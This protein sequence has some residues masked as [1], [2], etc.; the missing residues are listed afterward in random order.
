MG[1]IRNFFTSLQRRHTLR[2]HIWQSLANYTQQGFGFLLGIVLARLLPPAVFGAYG[3]AAATVILAL[4]P[5]TWSLA[6]TLLADAGKTPSLHT[7]V[8]QFSW[9]IVAARCVIVAAVVIWCFRAG[10]VTLGWL[11][12]LVG[13]TETFRELNN[14]QKGY[15]EGLGKFAPNFV[16]VVINM[17]FC[18]VVVIPLA[19]FHGGP[20]VLVLPALG[21]VLTDFVIYRYFSARTILVRPRWNVSR[22]F[23]HHGFWLWLGA[24]SE[25]GLARFDK[26]FVGRFR[27]E[28]PLGHYSRAF[29]YTPL[30]WLGLSSFATN[31]TVAGLTRCGTAAARL[32]LF[33][34]TSAILFAGGLLNWLAFFFFADQIVLGLFGRQWAPTIPI[35]RAFASLSLAYMIAY[36]PMTVMLAHRRYR[37]LGIVRL[38]ALVAFVAIVLLCREHLSPTSVAWLLQGTLAMQGLIL[39]Y[40]G[41]SSFQEHTD[42]I[43]QPV[44]TAISSDIIT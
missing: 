6:P 37:E 4:L 39:L 12:L 34:R 43:P 13:F 33:L 41:R 31:P 44:A 22:E 9:I 7:A 5:A 24:I 3:L 30:A 29:G 14:V 42:A 11:C 21:M 16:S 36:L 38:G 25:V 23:F 2:S 15:L 32:R 40:L 18:I 19:F 1:R 26:W 28:I 20:Y 35:F 8:A 10:Q 27:G 17:L